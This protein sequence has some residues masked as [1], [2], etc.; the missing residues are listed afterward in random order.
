MLG[1]CVGVCYT[2]VLCRWT[3]GVGSEGCIKAQWHSGTLRADQ[4]QEDEEDCAV[5]AGLSGL[6]V[7][8]NRHQWSTTVSRPAVPYRQCPE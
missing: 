3:R 6:Y 2:V 1:R 4:D 7:F 8:H 5:A